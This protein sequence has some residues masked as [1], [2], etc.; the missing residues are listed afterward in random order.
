MIKKKKV[1]L[2]VLLGMVCLTVAFFGYKKWHYETANAFY[3]SY[4]NGEPLYMQQKKLV[5]HSNSDLFKKINIKATYE[6]RSS[7]LY[8]ISKIK[9]GKKYAFFPSI[10]P[11]EL[12][13]SIYEKDSTNEL[14]SFVLNKNLDKRIFPP[15]GSDKKNYLQYKKEAMQ[16]YREIFKEIY[17]N[18]EIQ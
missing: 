3:L 17:E 7:T 12:Y 5:K 10:E 16:I 6:E 14:C 8:S 9:S 18:W 13:V 2:C 4:K 11:E 15:K 1:A